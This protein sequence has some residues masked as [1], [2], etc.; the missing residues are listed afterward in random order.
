VIAHRADSIPARIARLTVA[1]PS[2]LAVVDGA[3]QLTYGDLERQSTLLA[4]RLQEAGASQDR[5]VGILLERS[6]D[7]IIAALAVMKCGAAYV[8][9]DPS[10]PEGRV[11]A[12]L[13]DA[14]AFV[15]LTRSDKAQRSPV[16]PWRVIEFDA[17]ANSNPRVF[18]EFESDPKSLA[19]VIYTSGSTGEPKGVEITHENLCNLIDW[20]LTAF[21]VTSADRASQIASVGFDAVVWEIWPYLACG[22][23]LHI[24]DESTRR[25]SLAIR[26]WIVA[27]KITV[28]F[29]PTVLAEQLLRTYWPVDTVLRTL[30]TGG[31]AL[32]SRPAAGL[33]FVVINNYG[34][35]ECTVVATSGSV[36]VDGD[37]NRPPSIGRPIANA[38]ALILDD[39]LEPVANGEAGELCLGGALVGRGYR[40]RPELTASRFVT[41]KT[42]SGDCQRIYRTG[43]RAK[44]LENGEIAFLGRL[45]DQVKIRGYRIE[46]GE[47]VASLNR[48]IG[49]ESSAVTVRELGDARPAL[50]AYV[51]PALDASLTTTE[52]REFLAT[53]LPEY[54]VPAFYVALPKLPMSANG[55]VDRSALP[56]PCVENLLPKKAVTNGAS[57]KSDGLQHRISALVASLLCQPS[58]DAEENFFMA[59]GHSMLGAELVARIRDTFGV[60]ITLRQLFTAPTVAALSSQVARL[61][62][63]VQ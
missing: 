32:H 45:D 9:L 23:S 4:A 47:I 16:G 56:A 22:A 48:F 31:D 11:S 29:V 33:P 19:Y 8:P 2:R 21:N 40:N 50:I 25:S 51:I 35:T 10:T 53:S 44:L 46:L 7:F 52:L 14:G 54:M 61:M 49:I 58:I 38:T 63:A 39:A 30:L 36:S 28:S 59:G 62:E 20:H 15:L 26:D 13:A 42:A 43:D 5:C 55:K 57:S 37:T 3:A 24:A 18:A 6:A 41:Y 1:A 17:P 34:P 12:I 27:E 60:N